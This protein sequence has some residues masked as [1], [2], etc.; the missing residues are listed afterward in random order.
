MHTTCTAATDLPPIMSN[1]DDTIPSTREICRDSL[2]GLHGLP[3]TCRI[4][5]S[6]TSNSAC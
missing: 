3:D 6:V 1:A 5:C 4:A 2:R